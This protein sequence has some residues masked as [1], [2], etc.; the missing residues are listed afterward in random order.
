[1]GDF[2][3]EPGSPAYNLMTSEEAGFKSAHFTVH[4][5]E[6]ET[7]FPTGLQAEFM[8]VDPPMC[9]DY[10]FYKGPAS[11]EPLQAVLAGD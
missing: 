2:N 10:I 7:T 3:A 4:G 9:L 11:L 6:P 5:K 8:D 1:M